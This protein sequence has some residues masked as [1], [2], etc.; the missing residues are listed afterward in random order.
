MKFI[1]PDGRNPI[2][3]MFRAYRGYKAYRAARI[4]SVTTGVADAAAV[5]TTVVVSYNY[6]CFLNP[7]RAA[8][9]EQSLLDGIRDVVNQNNAV[10]PEYNN[11]RKRERDARD[12][13]NQEQANVVQSL[14]A[15]VSGVMPNRAAALKRDLND[16]E[17]KQKYNLEFLQQLL[18]LLVKI[19]SLKNCITTTFSAT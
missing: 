6:N 12:E 3:A 13:R 5:T 1:D 18:N 4:A 9:V 14:D 16:G 10:S 7:D 17:G 15:N 2:F 19:H 11:Q 8:K